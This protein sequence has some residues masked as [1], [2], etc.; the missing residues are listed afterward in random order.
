MASEISAM[1][2]GEPVLPDV[3]DM[4]TSELQQISN[5]SNSCN[6]AVQLYIITPVS[7]FKLKEDL[8]RLAV[9]IHFDCIV[10]WVLVYDTSVQNDLEPQFTDNPQVIEV[11][12]HSKEEADWGNTQRNKG[13][14]KVTQG[15]LYFLDDDNLM[16]PHFWEI[17]SNISLGHFTTFDQ[18]RMDDNPPR[19]LTGNEVRIGSTDTS[20]FT[21]DRALVADTKWNATGV[22]ADGVFAEEIVRKHPDRH[23]YI[24]GVAAYHNG[25][26]VYETS[27]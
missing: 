17:L 5:T 1:H 19:V 23:V 16:H 14:E 6:S 8:A 22:S 27:V 9:S 24:P 12:Y 25:L 18:I 10:S 15:L 3:T 2:A 20:M 26:V 13:M 11:Y 21:V 4:T 7:R